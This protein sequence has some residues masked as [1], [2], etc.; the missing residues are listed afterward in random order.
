MS[1]IA[2][3]I[4]Y[5]SEARTKDKLLSLMRYDEVSNG[6]CVDNKVSLGYIPL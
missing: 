5:C 6:I 2:S 3:I 4:Q 1:S